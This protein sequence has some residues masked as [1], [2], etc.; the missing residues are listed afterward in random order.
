MYI[1]CLVNAQSNRIEEKNSIVS[2]Y[3]SQK[4]LLHFLL[5]TRSYYMTLSAIHKENRH[6]F[7]VFSRYKSSYP[8]NTA[9]GP[10]IRK[11][12]IQSSIE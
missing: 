1:Q 10:N 8:Y 11:V 9:D 2:H 7:E 4:I 6:E 5:S 3:N 12:K